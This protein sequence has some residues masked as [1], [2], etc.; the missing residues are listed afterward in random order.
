MPSTLR[1][2][3][4]KTSSTNVCSNGNREHH[5]TQ[6]VS[7]HMT[8]HRAGKSNTRDPRPWRTGK[9]EKAET[10]RFLR[11]SEKRTVHHYREETE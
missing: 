1:A 6:E 3:C 8:N 5:L 7:A 9:A 11:R 4:G 10:N 2:V